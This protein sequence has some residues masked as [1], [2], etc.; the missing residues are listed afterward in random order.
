MKFEASS[1]MIETQDDVSIKESDFVYYSGKL[2]IVTQ[3]IESDQNKMKYYSNRPTIIR[4]IML[5]K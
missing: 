5:R 2:Y 1:G 3:V 4:K